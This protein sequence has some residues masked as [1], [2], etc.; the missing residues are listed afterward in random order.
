MKQQGIDRAE[1]E[2]LENE[3]DAQVAEALKKHQK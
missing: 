2:R 1:A 3:L